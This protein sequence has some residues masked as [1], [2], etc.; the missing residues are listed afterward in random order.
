MKAYKI[1]DLGEEFGKQVPKSLFHGHERMYVRLRDQ[2]V[3]VK[4][5][6]VMHLNCWHTAEIKPVTDGSRREPYQ[7]GFHCYTNFDAV[8]RWFK[9]ARAENR[10]IV[11]VEINDNP[12]TKPGAVRHTLLADRMKIHA[13]DWEHRIPA[14][15]LL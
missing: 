12:R 11:R 6:R 10:V 13:S 1:F 3:T 9:T 15:T 5:S 2:K 8:K 14:E 4:R 7:S